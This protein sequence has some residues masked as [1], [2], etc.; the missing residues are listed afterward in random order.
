MA[1]QP[2][3]ID[4]STARE[5]S[6]ISVVDEL[7]ELTAANSLDVMLRKALSM[8]I[9]LLG[10][11]A[12][13]ILFQAQSFHHFQSGPFRPEALARI[14]HWEEAIG[15]RLSGTAWDIPP[16]AAVPISTSKVGDNQLVL[17]NIPLVRDTTVV[18]SLS[19]VLPPSS[20]LTEARRGLLIRMAKGV[21]RIASRM[22]ELELAQQSL[23]QMEVFYQVGQAL[24]TTFDVNKLLSDT[25]QLAVNMIDAGAA[26]IMLIDEEKQELIFEVSH[27]SRAKMLRQQRIPLEEGIAGWVARHGQPVITNN[28][29]TDD[30]FSHRVD[31]RTGFLTQSIAAVPLRIKGRI[32]GVLEVLNKY[33]E[34]GFNQEDIRLMNSIAAQAA[35][36][37]ENARL[38]Q[39][40]RQE[41]DHI[42]KAQENVRRELARNLH[43]GPVQLL[44]AISMSL[45]H[46][47]RLNKVKP[48]A[49][50]NEITALRNLVNQA[51]RDA[52]NLLFEMRPVI[53]E[54]QGLVAALEEYVNQ[55]RGSEDFTIHFETVKHVDYDT[56]VAGTIFSVVQEAINNIKRHA[57]ARNVWLSFEIRNNQFIV[58]VRD[59]GTGFD[60]SKKSEDQ[61]RHFGL[62]NMRERA[63]LI[64]AELQIESRPESPNRGTTIRLILPLPADD[65]SKQQVDSI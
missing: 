32:I 27:G 15:K 18:G 37:I 21:G 33:S 34:E 60:V 62:L 29:R 65:S 58:T 28:A 26:S 13:S 3:P 47:E 30:R 42:I 53:L 50:H 63:E 51:T 23:K 40:V 45:D 35:I 20:E 41:R 59:D 44:S 38:Y 52:R 12:G 22:T 31:V 1:E 61:K 6:A 54:T 8:S 36:A 55:L 48:E 14:K 16:G 43:D 4:S 9:R 49:V 19:L 17:V 25:M 24:V 64:E 11:E 56:K 57:G 5:S 10:A 2:A 39:Q 46:L 7:F